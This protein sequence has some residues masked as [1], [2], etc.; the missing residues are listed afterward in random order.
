M[1]DLLAWKLSLLAAACA[2]ALAAPAVGAARQDEALADERA[3]AE[4]GQPA[5]AGGWG[6]PTEEPRDAKAAAGGL[7]PDPPPILAPIAT[8]TVEA[9]ANVDLPQ[10]I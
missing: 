6:L 7:E 10:D 5:G 2:A 9:N 4:T 1:R 8:E 3:A